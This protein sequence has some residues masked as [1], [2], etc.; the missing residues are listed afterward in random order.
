MPSNLEKYKAD[1]T[2]LTTKGELLQVAMEYEC[3]PEEVAELYGK[4]K[5]G[6][7]LLKALPN[8]GKKYQS[9]YSEA[10]SVIKQMLPDR[11][12]DFVRHYQKPK[13][14]KDI[15]YEN[16]R[17]EDYLQGLT[18]TRGW[19]KA[20]VVGKEAAIPHFRQQLAIMEAVAS[21]FESTLFD[22]RQIVQ[23]D[24]FD[25]EIDAARELLKK[26]FVRASGA[27]AGVVLEKHL[28]QVAQNHNITTRKRH[29]TISDFNDLL[30]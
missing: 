26:G 24:L 27:I 2:K 21:R 9:W 20:K 12:D 19:E 6:K 15:T 4:A 5:D 1:L 22:I 16:Y 29:P 23:A 28:A 30:K 18:I 3:Y 8:F 25:S 7:E 10:A 11:L 14:R 17:I 13:P